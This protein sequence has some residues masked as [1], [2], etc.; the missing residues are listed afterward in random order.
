[1]NARI[2]QYPC[3]VIVTDFDPVDVLVSN[4]D[5]KRFSFP[6]DDGELYST[7]AEAT[8]AADWFKRVVAPIL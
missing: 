1:M 5:T 3:S 4:E 7:R 8:E 2:E 6:F